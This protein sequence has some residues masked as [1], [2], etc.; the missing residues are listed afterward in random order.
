[1]AEN[2]FPARTGEVAPVRRATEDSGSALAYPSGKG[3]A[4]GRAPQQP[5]EAAP[6]HGRCG[7]IGARRDFPRPVERNVN[8]SPDP[9][10]IP[11]H[12]AALYHRENGP[13]ETQ[14]N[15]RRGI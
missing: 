6:I 9:G 5:G 3:I 7:T 2:T 15:R 13:E 10:R 8:G 11:E 12:G 1:M 4:G 14:G